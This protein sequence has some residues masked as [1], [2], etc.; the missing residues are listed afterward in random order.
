MEKVTVY[1]NNFLPFLSP[2]VSNPFSVPI[3]V[4][5]SSFLPIRVRVR[6]SVSQ[7]PT[8]FATCNDVNKAS[9]EWLGSKCSGLKILLIS[10]QR[11]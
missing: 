8:C 5:S 6:L 1:E 9:P 2:F 3:M 10:W 4:T 11:D 7:M